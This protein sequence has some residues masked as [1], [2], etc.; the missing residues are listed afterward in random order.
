M[1]IKIELPGKPIYPGWGDITGNFEDQTDVK[2]YIDNTLNDAINERLPEGAEFALG[3]ATPSTTPPSSPI[4][5]QFYTATEEGTYTNLSG[6]EL[7]EG[8]AAWITYNGISWVKQIIELSAV[9]VTNDI[10]ITDTSKALSGKA[11]GDF[12]INNG[13]NLITNLIPNTF[14]Q[15]NN[16]TGSSTLNSTQ[17]NIPISQRGCYY[18]FR[19]YLAVNAGPTAQRNNSSLLML[20]N[21]NVIT[22]VLPQILAAAENGI[23]EFIFYVPSNINRIS[24]SV[25]IGTE[26]EAFLGV[27][28]YTD[29][30]KQQTSD[31]NSYREYMIGD[32][33]LMGN[34]KIS[35]DY[36]GDWKLR[37]TLANIT[38]NN[39]DGY[40][41]VTTGAN[42]GIMLNAYNNELNVGVTLDISYD[43]KVDTSCVVDVYVNGNT[44]ISNTYTNTIWEK[45][46]INTRIDGNAL[47]DWR[48]LIC[49]PTA[50]QTFYIR[51]ISMKVRGNI[52]PNPLLLDESDI[53]NNENLLKTSNK[54]AN[55]ANNNGSDL[56]VIGMLGDSWVQSVAGAINYVQELAMLLRET[57][58]NGGA[59][60]YDFSSGNGLFR[61]AVLSDITE[62]RGG[63]IT[64]V[65]QSANALGINFAHANFGASAF[66]SLTINEPQTRGV[67]KFYGG[68][69][70]GEFR[71]QLN[72]GA[73]VNVDTSTL[74]GFNELTISLIGATLIRIERV[75]GNVILLGID[76]QNDTGVRVHKLGNRGLRSDQV[77]LVN[78]ENWI[79][80]FEALECDNA[81][82][83][84]GTNDRTDDDTPLYVK[85]N[86]NYW[87]DMIGNVELALIAP[88]N[89]KIILEPYKMSMYARYIKSIA[90]DRGKSFI[91][92]IP[93]FGSSTD[94]ITY[95][96]FFDDYHPTEAQGKRIAKYIYDILFN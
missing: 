70:Y 88:S 50:G 28:S 96:S 79:E 15:N 90:I 89:N 3:P 61:C 16:N 19:G 7:E 56:L 38:S 76:F 29:F 24:V 85:N 94:I 60:Y 62:S 86:I 71:Y 82:I 32:N 35:D 59:G 41:I 78:R 74:D 30:L 54:I 95:G 44:P 12:L 87:L 33:K 11:V 5:G 80:Q 21:T 14:L 67:L 63:S 45:K 27:A 93:L 53:I 20:T 13:S 84:I 6:I 47:L 48:T 57:Y 75:S 9:D 52:I 23:T 10:N 8:E 65:D 43:I 18:K 31:S 22:Q 39:G 83:L 58:G 46:T 36:I 49:A 81:T 34:E 69:S 37:T 73:W 64:Y 91:N 72:G 92:L 77:L 55:L 26:T 2:N 66:V 17:V 25:R 68:A 51:N 4:K 1:G 42:G 40:K